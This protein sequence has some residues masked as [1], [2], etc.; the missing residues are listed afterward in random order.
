M[1]PACAAQR[2][3]AAN[4]SVGAG[5]VSAAQAAPHLA[6]EF[7]HL[8]DA[9]GHPVAGADLST[10]R[11]GSGKRARWRCACGH[12]WIKTIAKRV[13]GEGC[14]L[15]AR[16]RVAAQQG[17][18][19]PG[20]ESAADRWPHLVELFIATLERPDLDLHTL[21]P[22]SGLRCRWRC[23]TCGGE[24]VAAVHARADAQGCSACAAARAKVSR[25][26]VAPGRS[27][28]ELYPEVAEQF[29]D[30]LT[31][32]GR[33]PQALAM[34]SIDVCRWRCR[35]GHEWQATVNTRTTGR[36]CAACG[37]QGRSRS[38]SRWRTCCAPRPARSCAPTCVTTPQGGGGHS[39]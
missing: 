15:C 16:A 3:G 34:G 22:S 1:C 13:A 36:G 19:R 31:T 4:A 6:G 28:A 2:A 21:S 32:P 17:R 37:S 12:T 29:L 30:N 20:E 33:G 10:V 14:P 23:P 5:R 7:V 24:H 8:L 27:L 26:I 18:V 39:T 38:S 35:R 9:G 11:P 25:R